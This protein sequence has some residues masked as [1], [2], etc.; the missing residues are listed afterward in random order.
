MNNKTTELASKSLDSKPD[1][2]L[3][4]LQ[5]RDTVVKCDKHGD[6]YVKQ[7]KVFSD[8]SEPTCPQCDEDRIA[9]NVAQAAA[10]AARQAISDREKRI[11]HMLDRANIPQRFAKKGFDDYATTLFDT[12]DCKE[13]CVRYADNFPQLRTNGTGLVLAGMTGTGKTHLACAIA[14]HIIAKHG[15]SALYITSARAFR[16]VKATYNARGATNEQ[17]ALN[18]LTAP[19]LLV[20]D[21]VGASFGSDAEKM[22]LF[23]IVNER[24]EKMRPTMLLSNLALGAL[25]EVAGQRV[26][27]RM[28]ENGG[29]FLTFDWPSHRGN[30]K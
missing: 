14:K 15:M 13:T 23:D 25:T 10:I 24:Y 28:K 7:V 30:E 1:S 22:I 19:D 20:L 6:I 5:T 17:D 2:E 16:S 18:T 9:H 29:M 4:Q 8:Y 3:I 12:G 26:I 11:I 21:E 27:D